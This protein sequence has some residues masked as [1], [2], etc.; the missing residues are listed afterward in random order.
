MIKDQIY[1]LDN[2]WIQR[3]LDPKVD[4]LKAIQT[5]CQM[6]VSFVLF[7]MTAL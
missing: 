3:G 5:F 6:I 7:V 4:F 2:A 1:D